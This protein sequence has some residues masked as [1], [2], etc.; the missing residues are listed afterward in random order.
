M[1]S[2]S[3]LYAEKIYAEHPQFLWALD[4]QADYVSIISEEQRNTFTW[5][6]DNGTSE[7]TEE[8]SDAPF[9]DSVINKVTPTTVADGTF[10]VTLVS[11]NTVT[12]S[13]LNSVLKTFCVGSYFYTT[14]SF[15]LNIEIGY[16][17]YDNA[18]DQYLD[19]LKSY[20]ASL[21]ERWYF[22]SE[23]FSPEET[24]LPLRLVIKINYIG[25]NTLTPADC[26]FY[27]NG[28]T[29]G[30]WSEEFQSQSLGATAIDMPSNIALE[31]SKVVEAKA[32]GL[33]E[34]YGYYFINNNALMAKNFGVPMV[35]GSK[36]VT[37]LYHNPDKPS[38][39]IPS[40]G[41]FSEVG[42][43]Q[44]FTLEFWLR[45]RNSS[46]ELKRIIGP[47][48][49]DD[50]L[51]INGPF[52]VL[53]VNNKYASY[54]VGHWE[55]PMLLHWRYSPEVSTLLLN[56]EE[57]MSIQTDPT[58]LSFPDSLNTDGDTSDWIGFYAHEDIEPIEVD[59]VAIYNYLVPLL[60]AK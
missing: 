14:S 54:Y 43:Y 30:Q 24:D 11:Q 38:L 13:E 51:Y 46:Q 16:R 40:G 15:A 27:I 55:R 23:T 48:A 52:L 10:A 45:T 4:D 3:N 34:N 44:T 37:K 7:V 19:V 57:V 60:V 21:T 25:D 8:L 28:I 36:N 2:P 53:K 59:C 18:Q 39:I 33:A 29:F 41:M 42:K 5:S 26:I 9:P 58:D 50:G 6:I 32:Y 22:I 17:Y 12:V 1:S 20:D 47:I 56:G 35:F 31:S 49:S